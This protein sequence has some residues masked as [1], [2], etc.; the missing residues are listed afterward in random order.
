MTIWAE[1]QCE[2]QTSP[3]SPIRMKVEI[4]RD[5]VSFNRSTLLFRILPLRLGIVMPV[6]LSTPSLELNIL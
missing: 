6:I 5:E 1:T 3:S 2:R 4:E